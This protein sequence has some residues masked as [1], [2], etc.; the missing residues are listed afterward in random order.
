MY[1]TIKV[2]KASKRLILPLM[3]KY[4]VKTLSCLKRKMVNTRLELQRLRSNLQK[5]LRLMHLPTIKQKLLNTIQ[6]DQVNTNEGNKVHV[7]DLLLQSDKPY[8]MAT[9]PNKNHAFICVDTGSAIGLMNKD[10]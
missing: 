4:G 8:F 10:F 3:K 1:A 2:K 5:D 6:I 9:F 7:L